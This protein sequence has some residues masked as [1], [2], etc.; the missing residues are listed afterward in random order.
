MLRGSKMKIGANELCPCGSGKK[1]K[2]CCR[3]KDVD[4]W[5]LWRKNATQ[6]ADENGLDKRFAQIFYTLMK[7]ISNYNWRGACH[8]ASAILYVIFRELGYE[9]KLCAG[10]V[11]TDFWVTGHS[12][13][14][15]ESEVYDVSCYFPAVG[16]PRTMPVFCGKELDSMNNTETL[17]GI[18]DAPPAEDVEMVMA[19]TVSQIMSADQKKLGNKHLWQALVNVCAEAEISLP[20]FDIKG[21]MMGA[22]VINKKYSSAKWEL[23]NHIVEEV[24][25]VFI[26]LD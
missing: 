3:D 14:E 5:T 24:P 9:P 25:K 22:S 26:K 16:T 21:N 10:V 6:I 15:L 7:F 20:I 13:V 8:S 4:I 18:S 11:A 17:Y 12:W 23:R 19:S 1:Y 2:R